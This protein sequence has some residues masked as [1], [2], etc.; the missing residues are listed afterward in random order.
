MF[1][2]KTAV[3]TSQISPLGDSPNI[4]EGSG[5][6]FFPAGT[7]GTSL[8]QTGDSLAQPRA[9]N[10]ASGLLGQTG[11]AR[12]HNTGERKARGGID[13]PRVLP[14]TGRRGG[15]FEKKRAI[16]W[17]KTQAGET[18]GCAE[19]MPMALF[20]PSVCL[21]SLIRSVVAVG[22]TPQRQTERKA[23]H[24]SK[25]IWPVEMWH[26]LTKMPPSW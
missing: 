17:V 10:P 13:I 6:I 26:Q 7:T 20:C 12:F 24:P 23:I 19:P 9:T 14:E 16:F 22:S 5:I 8:A 4:P 2:K 1:C 21:H 18:P 3:A 15:F 11:H 25:C